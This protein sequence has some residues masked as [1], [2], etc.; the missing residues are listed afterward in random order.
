MDFPHQG[1]AFYEIGEVRLRMGDLKAAEEAFGRCEEYGREVPFG[2]QPGVAILRLLQ[3]KPD[4]A[5]AS[6]KTTLADGAL[7]PLLRAQL[8]PAAVEIF[9]ATGDVAAA[10]G[11]AEELGRI[12]EKY[13][14]IALR[15][16]AL[17]AAGATDLADGKA[18]DALKSLRAALQLW[19][20]VGATYEAARVRLAT[21]SAHRALGSESDAQHEFDSALAVF[22]S[23]GAE[24]DRE[25][26]ARL[27]GRPPE[28]RP[29]AQRVT[30]TFMFTDIVG[31]TELVA[32]LGDDAWCDLLNWHDATLRSLFAE[33]SGEEIKQ[34]G[35]GFFIAFT[36]PDAAI[37]CAVAVQQ[38]LAGHRKA[39]GFA[40]RVRIGVHGAEATHVS[41]DFSGRAVNEAA[42]IGALAG[43]DEI[44][45]SEKTLREAGDGFKGSAATPMTL[46]G[47]PE[48]VP[49]V[50]IDWH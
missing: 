23:L 50:A 35:D 5:I 42:R 9:L 34:I 12:A 25:A 4:E 2:P 41:G 48:P 49:V 19:H 22:E 14:T 20:E 46:K 6:I 18:V 40:P 29:R 45:V 36:N 27:L 47:I 1:G 39:N 13:Q 44:L 30:R 11:C 43:A 37:Q 38:R 33:H 24:R 3:G 32:S 15:A 7:S 31:S 26:A 17:S 28:S 10:R 16:H 21:G 8:L